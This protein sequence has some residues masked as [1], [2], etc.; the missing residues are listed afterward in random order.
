[1]R[2]LRL[3][4]YDDDDDDNDNDDNNNNNFFSKKFQK[5]FGVQNLATESLKFIFIIFG[6]NFMDIFVPDVQYF[7]F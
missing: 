3:P 1:M 6:S 7:N 5:N 4:N 2:A